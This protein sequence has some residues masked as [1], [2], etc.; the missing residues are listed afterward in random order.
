MER[1][2]AYRL[3]AAIVLTQ[4]AGL[5]GS[6]FTAPS[7]ATWYAM[8]QKPSFTP[9]NFV[10]GPVWTALFLL[11]G[12]SLYIVWGKGLHRKNVRNAIYVFAAQLALN[13][14]WSALFFGLQNPAAAFVEIILLWIA[15]ALTIVKFYVI[16]KRAA[17]L[18][19]PYIVWVSFAAF[20]NYSIWVLN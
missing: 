17:Y 20:L 18:L 8:I 7:I 1:R 14:V 10:F 4:L 11:M 19:V 12:I 6:I 16:D 3:I 15:I 9:P 13:V 2:N 5:I